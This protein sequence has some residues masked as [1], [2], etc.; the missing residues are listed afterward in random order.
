[1]ADG[2]YELKIPK[3]QPASTQPVVWVEQALGASVLA[4]F[5]NYQ[6]RKEEIL[7]RVFYVIA[8]RV[9]YPKLAEIVEKGMFF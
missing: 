5:K 9:T 6:S 4:L 3:F 1:M 7:G 2:S 8:A